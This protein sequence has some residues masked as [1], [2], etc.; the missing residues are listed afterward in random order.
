MTT[1]LGE[2]AVMSNSRLSPEAI[3]RTI[4]KLRDE[5]G[6]ADR[7]R[8]DKLLPLFQNTAEV[9]LGAV[10]KSLFPG[11]EQEAALTAFRQFR[12]RLKDIATDTGLDLELEA[13]TQTRTPPN[14]RSCWFSGAD[15]ATEAMTQLVEQ[16]TAHVNRSNQGAFELR[17]GKTVI[18]YFLSFSHKDETFKKDLLERLE[19]LLNISSKYRFEIWHDGLILPGDKWHEQIQ[20]AIENCHFGLL[21]VSPAFLGSPYIREHELP[22]FI[23]GDAATREDKRAIPVALKPLLFDGIIDLKGLQ[24]RQVFMDN[25]GKAY[26]KR[27]G[28]KKD[29]FVSQLFQRIVQVIEQRIILA[30]S[31]KKQ[32]YSDVEQH[33]R[34]HLGNMMENTNFVNTQGFVGNLE[35]LDSEPDTTGNE[36]IPHIDA[37][38]YLFEWVNDPAAPAYCVLLGDTGMGKTTTCMAFAQQLLQERQHDNT[39]PLPI[40]L[41]LRHL[42][43]KAQSSPSLNEILEVLLSKSWLGGELHINLAATDVI[44]LVQQ[45]GALLIFDGLDEVLMHLTPAAEQSFTREL[46]RALPPRKANKPEAGSGRLLL[47]CRTHFFRTLRD[48]KN[49]LLG[50][51]REPLKP[52]DYRAFVLLPFSEEQIRN[53]L[54]Q[55]LPDEDPDRLLE[56]IKAVHNLTEMAER[57]YTLS[58]I[59]NAIPQLEQW[60]LQGRRVTGVTLYRH[61]V[62]SWL[63]RDQGKH[64]ITPEH[65]QRL[66]EYFAAELWRSGRRTWSVSDIEQWLIDLL[67]A[68]PEIAAHYQ[69]KGRE[70]LKE[71]LRTATFLVRD[72][73]DQ[74]RFAHTSLQE[75]F[76][77][78]H[79][80][81][82][83]LEQLPE[84]WVL[85]K[86]S[87]ETL[88]FLGQLL[89][90]GS[91]ERKDQHALALK[92]LAMLRDSYRPQAS[93]LAFTYALRALTQG[94]PAV[95][96]SGVRLEG[97]NLRNLEIEGKPGQRFNLRKAVFSGAHLEEARFRHVDLEEADFSQ[98]AMLRTELLDCRAPGSRFTSADLAG[99]TF[100]NTQLTSASFADARCHRTNWL[101]CRLEAA[102][103]LPDQPPSGFFAPATSAATLPTPTHP[104]TPIVMD[105]YQGAVNAVAFSPD[106]KRIVSGSSDQTL[107]LWDDDSGDCLATLQGHQ[108]RVNAVAFSPDGKRIVSGSS[109]QTLRLWDADS[110]DCLATLQGHQG[111]VNAVAFSPNGSRLLAGSSSGLHFY[112]AGE[113]TLERQILMFQDDTWINL[114][115][116]KQ[117]VEQTHGEAWRWLR[118]RGVNPATGKTELWPAEQF[119][120][121]PEYQPLADRSGGNPVNM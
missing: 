86:V 110:G 43:D 48:Q 119:G 9:S 11:M 55:T 7:E 58:L 67:T 49:L 2:D 18:R 77:A 42:G 66:M 83:L 103:G 120:A 87:P 38:N 95:S 96:Q 1:N 82:A 74:F 29:D 85:P 5:L 89:L 88:D 16:E 117:E 79:L 27:S 60:K 10:H 111:R 113:L 40:Y 116:A 68:R 90:E 99:T 107:R 32:P 22:Q 17:E 61:M 35:K 33:F 104:I 63:E 54:H 69:G 65:K 73:E 81:R 70:L 92:T 59:S 23:P 56:L 34:D 44:R 15:G 46:L 53:Y 101:N 6:R 109:D 39:L 98:A 102:I 41:D 100:R 50:E 62:L 76:L 57:P 84:R 4:T 12:K 31:E 19:V 36:K 24:H 75:F 37:L 80:Y 112:Q 114:N 51:D 64:T 28:N 106:G 8:I 26:S 71:D 3:R 13:D 118:W 72:G 108:G 47:S 45:Q 121:L 97:M 21:L 115:V 91:E 30:A 105:G 20:N 14:Q 78:C 93:E 52:T 25:E 94:H